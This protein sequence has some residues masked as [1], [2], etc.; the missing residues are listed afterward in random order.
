MK[1]EGYYSSGQFAKMAHVSVR[2]IRFYDQKNLL[3]PSLIAESGARFYTELD[4]VK[5][6]QI[7]LLKYLGFSLEDIKEIGMG[8]TDRYFLKT[9]LAMQKKLIEGRLEEMQQVK[10]SIDATLENLEEGQEPDWENML[11]LIHLTAMENSLKKQY[12]NASNI[13][14]RIRIHD[15]YS[16]NPQS[17]FSWICEK[18]KI[19]NGMRILEVGCGNGA[20]WLENMEKLCQDGITN[21][22]L[23]ISDV[24]DGVVGDARR[25]ILDYLKNVD[26]IHNGFD[27]KFQVFDCAEIPYEADSFDL[28][29]A[30]HVMFY[31][32]DIPAVCEEIGRV[33]KPQGRLV[34]S[35]Y[36]QNHMKEIREVVKRFDDRIVLSAKELYEIFGLDNGAELLGKTFQHIE[37]EHYKDEIILDEANPLIEYVLS[38]HGNQN[39]YLLDRYNEFKNF[40]VKSVGKEFHI[41]K[42]AGVFVCSRLV[43]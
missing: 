39:K 34:C 8:Q 6:Q 27:F 12:Q 32:K 41:T 2:T 24:S 14:A 20:M 38:C 26:F 1:K 4:F 11:A 23:V 40:I 15:Q 43:N 37:L 22:Q 33:L 13:S 16:V 18:C 17:W 5:L 35:T 3:K 30:N 31:C 25:G 19:K 7:L 10:Q 42:D 9:A 21:L 36:G 29:I 28:V